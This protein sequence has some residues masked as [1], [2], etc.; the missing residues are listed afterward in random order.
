MYGMYGSELKLEGAVFYGFCIDTSLFIFG[1]WPMLSIPDIPG[2]PP[3]Y[4]VN[5]TKKVLA[6]PFNPTIPWLK[7]A[8]GGR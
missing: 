5:F 2:L 3:D 6:R 1:M 8:C 7:M 4:G